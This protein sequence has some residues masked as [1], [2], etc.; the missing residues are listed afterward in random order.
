MQITHQF[1]RRLATPLALLILLGLGFS[2]VRELFFV[3][4]GSPAQVTIFGV[5]CDKPSASRVVTLIQSSNFGSQVQV[6]ERGAKVFLV[7]E[8]GQKRAFI[9]QD[10]GIYHFPEKD[11]WTVPERA[12][13]LEIELANG[14]RYR[15]EVARMPKPL[16]IKHC[17]PLFRENNVVNRRV[18]LQAA[19]DLD[20]PPDSKGVYLRWE[21]TRVWQ[22]TSVDLATIFQ[23]YMRFKP[24]V[25]CYL[26]DTLTKQ[27]AALFGSPRTGGFQLRSQVLAEIIAD[28]RM[29]EINGMEVIQYRIDAKAYEYWFQAN[30]LANPEGSVFDPPPAKLQGNVFQENQPEQRLLGRFDLAAIDTATF[31][32]EKDFF[33][34]NGYS[35]P[36]P[37][38]LDNGKIEWRDTYGFSP[39]C[40]FCVLIP[41]HTIKRPYYFHP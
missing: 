19:V 38:Y 29:Y 37:C 22:R 35:L 24:P 30:Q 7:D 9:E 11:F 18:A 6:P 1:L 34:K 26:Y 41:G 12:Y 17:Y 31:T 8:Q 14:R 36:D 10:P 4:D 28:E 3:T 2:C 13:H 33:I 32:V 20:I 25:R 40:A 27:R 23:D 39:G 16:E 15:S 21:V 5:F